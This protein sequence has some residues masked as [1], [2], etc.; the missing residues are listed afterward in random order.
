MGRINKAMNDPKSAIAWAFRKTKMMWS[1]EKYLKILYH[2]FY[3]EKLHLNNPFKYS[4]KMQWLKLYYRR[5]IFTK[6]V[7]KYEVKRIVSEAIGAEYV[8]PCYGIWDSFDEIDFDKLP[9]QF[10]LKCTHDSGS[11]VICKDKA[12][13]DKAAAKER[14]ERNRNKNFFYEFREWPYK[15]VKPRI[16]AEKYEPSLGKIDS[17]EYKL[18]CCDGEVKTITVCGGVPHADFS[19]RSNDNFSKDWTRQDWY[20]YYK[21]KGGEIKKPS[22]MDKIVELSETLSAG[23]P[24]VR[25]DWYII[26]EKPY[27]GEFTF[28]TWAGFLRFTPQEWDSKM[29]EWIKLPDIK[30]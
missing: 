4:E 30:I 5:P 22:Q 11:F 15:D 25:V 19:L 28:Y 3:G 18:T 26:D 27:F 20:A 13:F 24:Y 6:M 17:V 12:T 9:K 14:L 1:D 21:P 16:L 8:I 2:L 23:I 29:G 7:D 10:C